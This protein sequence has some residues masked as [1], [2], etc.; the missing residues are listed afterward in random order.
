MVELGGQRLRIEGHADLL[1]YFV[2][3]RVFMP[4]AAN[5]DIP[6]ASKG[7]NLHQ[8][9]EVR[10]SGAD[11]ARREGATASVF[12]CHLRGLIWQRLP[13]CCVELFQTVFRPPLTAG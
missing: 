1:A 11:R 6:H 3:A 7:L 8:T 2:E 9:G 12:Q 5:P 13:E 4:T 10:F